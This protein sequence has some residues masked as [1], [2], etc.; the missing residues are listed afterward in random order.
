LCI[1]YKKIF[2]DNNANKN[3]CKNLQK[4][5]EDFIMPKVSKE[6]LRSYVKEQNFKSS[7]DVLT[8]MKEMF[9]DVL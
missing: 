4:T 6:L 2:L 5:K 3:K 9:A 1:Q 8:A 7:K